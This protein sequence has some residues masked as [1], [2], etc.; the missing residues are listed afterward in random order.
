MPSEYI[1]IAEKEG[2]PRAAADYISGMTDRYAINQYKRLF[3]PE[4][5]R[6]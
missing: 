2:V 1:E 6:G 4:P 5:F 3:I